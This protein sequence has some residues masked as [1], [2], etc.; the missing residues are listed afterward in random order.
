MERIIHCQLLNALEANHLIS[1]FQH[2]FRHQ[3]S[4]ITLLL[5]AVHD[6]AS[7]L[8]KRHSVHCI[9]LDLAKAF[10]YVPHSRLLLKLESLGIWGN[11]LSWLKFFLTR[12]F[13]RVVI[14]GVFSDWL[15]VLSVPQ[16]S[17]LGPLLFFTLHRQH[18]SLS[19]SQFNSNVC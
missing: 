14:N 5:S 11:L 16:G 19:Y 17:V 10:D 1:N 4:T 3:H 13:Q 12:C 7:F 8:E 18:P 9:F 2:G 6:W 15:P